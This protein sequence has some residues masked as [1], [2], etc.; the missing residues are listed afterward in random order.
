MSGSV[1]KDKLKMLLPNSQQLCVYAVFKHRFDPVAY[2]AH[3]VRQTAKYSSS[4]IF[5][6]L[7][8]RQLYKNV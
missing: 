1:K 8:A 2:H 4:Q 3:S 5:T 7:V 6:V